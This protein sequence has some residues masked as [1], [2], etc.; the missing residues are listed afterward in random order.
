MGRDVCTYI[1]ILFVLVIDEVVKEAEK[2]AI[3][4]E[5]GQWKMQAVKTAKFNYTNYK[6]FIGKDEKRN[7]S[8]KICKSNIAIDE[9]RTMIEKKFKKRL[10]SYLDVR[11]EIKHKKQNRVDT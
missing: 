4:C 5:A 3:Q 10:H 9:T 6:I 8:I 7:L 11:F 1:Q 2:E